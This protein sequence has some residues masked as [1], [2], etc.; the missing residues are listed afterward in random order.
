MLPKHK[1]KDSSLKLCKYVVFLFRLE[2]KNAMNEVFVP[3]VCVYPAQIELA[4]TQKRS[5]DF[6]ALF[7]SLC[8]LLF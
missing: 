2:R 3:E 8:H 4:N 7:L 1:Q 6:S 5:Q